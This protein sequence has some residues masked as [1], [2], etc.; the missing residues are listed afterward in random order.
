MYSILMVLLR[1]TL[2]C[3]KATDFE[4][5]IFALV[6]T[7]FSAH[8]TFLD[9]W[10]GSIGGLTVFGIA[11]GLFTTALIGGLAHCL[12]MCGPFVLTQAAGRQDPSL[13][14]LS[15]A[16][17]PGYHL[18][19]MT[20]YAALGAMAGGFGQSLTMIL[21]LRWIAVVLLASAAY[22]FLVRGLGTTS[23]PFPRH[24]L[25]KVGARLGGGLAKT[26][27]PLLRRSR[28]LSGYGLGLA[29]GLLPCGFLYG[30]LLGAAATTNFIAGG[31][32]MV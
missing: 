10:C 8:L 32:V 23:S 4:A 31:L 21:P 5:V 12:P 19:R 13:G 26:V 18:G 6:G 2:I 24:A 30:A 16:L 11:L 17:L 22:S 25:G 7:A 3:I 15:N 28:R 20:T 14:R 1:S 9:A 27:A 29:L